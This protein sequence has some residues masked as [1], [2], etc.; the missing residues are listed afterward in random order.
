LNEDNEKSANLLVKIRELEKKNFLPKQLWSIQEL[1]TT[2]QMKK[3]GTRVGVSFTFLK[4]LYLLQ[5]KHP[6][7]TIVATGL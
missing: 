3:H 2:N 5:N 4:E 1:F 6:V 7:A